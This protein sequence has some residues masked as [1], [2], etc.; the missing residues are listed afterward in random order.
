MAESLQEGR[1]KVINHYLMII[2]QSVELLEAY[3]SAG[4]AE[5]KAEEIKSNVLERILKAEHFAENHLTHFI[6][7][8]L[9]KASG[10]TDES[11]EG[12][13]A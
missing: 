6:E 3:S 10:Q 4:N 9:K 12:S 2:G 1:E 7:M 13:Q 8:L 11:N 5:L